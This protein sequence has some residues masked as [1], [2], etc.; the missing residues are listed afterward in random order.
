[1]IKVKLLLPASISRMPPALETSAAT[2]I[3]DQS[4]DTPT[5]ASARA[6]PAPPLLKVIREKCIDCCGGQ[7]GEVRNCVTKTCALWPYRM[8]TNPFSNRKGNPATLR[9]GAA[10]A[11]DNSDPASRGETCQ[12]DRR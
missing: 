12:T 2:T 5:D 11:N 6:Q 7:V 9:P 8:A 3:N 4:N 10:H 1:L